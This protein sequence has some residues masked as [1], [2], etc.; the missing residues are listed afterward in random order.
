M[1]CTDNQRFSLLHCK[2]SYR[3]GTFCIC[4]NI[5]DFSTVLD[6]MQTDIPAT[7]Y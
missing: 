4:Q 5:D 7:H 3:N 6:I 1:N 2:N